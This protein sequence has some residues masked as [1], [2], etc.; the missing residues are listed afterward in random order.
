MKFFKRNTSDWIFD[1][2][3]ILLCVSVVI[4]T[5]YPIYFI[6]IASIS[7]PSSVANGDV[8]LIPK[9]ITMLGY[10]EIF[11]DQR[12]G[13]GYRNTLIYA[14]G[15]TACSMIFTIPAAYA[16]SRK[17]LKTGNFIMLVFAFTM[18][19]NRGLIP[20]Y[21]TVKQFNIDNSIWVMLIPFSVNVLILLQEPFFK[22]AYQMEY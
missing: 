11:K 12:I 7:N 13:V 6:I 4:I 18:F 17:D 19:F 5:L 2:F 8:W 15:G 14:L 20:T 16:L 3:L 1:L 9:K 10:K 22:T 21:L